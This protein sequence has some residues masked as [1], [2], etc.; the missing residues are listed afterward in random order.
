MASDTFISHLIEL[1]DRL[2][3]IVMGFGIVLLCLMPFANKLYSALAYPLLSKLP[4][5][6]QMI[7]TG[8]TTSFFVPMKVAMLAAFILSFPFTLY[9][10]WAFVAP[11]LYV[12]ERRFIAPMIISS[13]VLFLVGM[14][15]A[16]FAVFPLVFGFFV[17]TAPEGVAVMTDIGN[18]LDFIITMFIA[19]GMAFEVPVA[20]VLSVKLGLVKVETL[21]E[22]RPYVIVAAFVIGAIFTPPDV[23]SQCMLAL[24]LCILY[25]VGIW[26]AA[27][28][29][30]VENRI[31]NA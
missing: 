5:G 26:V 12:H 3:R 24:P 27:W 8:V 11:G 9:Q 14:A 17:N 22:V 7:A 10:I 6:G 20:V 18:Y 23:I 4:E 13:C 29:A 1:R 25:Q 21:K 31:E 19:F 15:F 2:I 28:V 16:Y 30:P